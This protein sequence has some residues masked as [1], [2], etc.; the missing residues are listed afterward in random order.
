MSDELGGSGGVERRA[1][2]E[3]RL[4][5]GGGYSR[6]ESLADQAWFSAGTELSAPDR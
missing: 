6:D 4:G 5:A 1:R 3:R 2:A